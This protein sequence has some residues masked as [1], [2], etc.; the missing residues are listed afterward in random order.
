[1]HICILTDY[2]INAL[3]FL[4]M[5][6]A[7]YLVLP[8]L[9]IFIF[10]FALQHENA[11]G[12]TSIPLE[13]SSGSEGTWDLMRLD[14]VI[15]NFDEVIATHKGKVVYLDIWASWCGPCIIGHKRSKP[16]KAEYADK[17]VVFLY[18]S[19]DESIRAW[20]SAAYRFNL[21]KDSYLIPDIYSSNLVQTLS[22][23]TIPRYVIYDK[24]GKLVSKHAPEPGSG[25]S[26][27]LLDKYLSE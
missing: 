7:S 23:S 15:E 14:S 21:T 20:E 5:K 2:L 19:L 22:V 3:K 26:R 27:K 18:V 12:N 9:G 6:F 8:L 25:K 24:S 4:S 17:D 16:F 11:A 10:S 13:A 1:M